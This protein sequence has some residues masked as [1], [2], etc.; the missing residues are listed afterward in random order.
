MPDGACGLLLLGHGGGQGKDGARLVRLCRYYAAQTGLSVVCI[1][2]IDHG[3]RKAEV[4]A[5]GVPRGWHSSTIPS[6]VADWQSVV[7]HLSSIGPPV[8]YVGFSMGAI[9]GFPTVASIPSIRAAVFVVGG[10]PGDDWTDDADLPPT[11]TRAGSGLSDAHV[12]M[13]N[14]DDDDLFAAR[15]VHQVFD[16]VAALSKRLEFWPGGHDDWGPDLI[17]QSVLFIKEHARVGDLAS[18]ARDDGL[19]PEKG[20]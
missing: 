9:F 6:M 15:G 20:S 19:A 3:E 10:I 2:A 1:D 7:E 12:L 5:G 13:L 11:L 8:A 4:S 16:S 17:D 18:A 14:K